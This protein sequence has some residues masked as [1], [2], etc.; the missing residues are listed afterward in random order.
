MPAS[1][2]H[3]LSVLLHQGSNW[4]NPDAYSSTVEVLLDSASLG[5][6][7]VSG[8][9]GLAYQDYPDWMMAAPAVGVFQ[10]N[11]SAGA[12]TV[13]LRQTGGN[14]CVE[15]AQDGRGIAL[16]YDE[17]RR[18]S[19]SVPNV[20][21]TSW[22]YDT[23]G[24]VMQEEKAISGAVTF[25]TAY[26]YDALDRVATMTYPGGEVVHHTYNAQPTTPPATC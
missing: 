20:D 12:H 26:T 11:A 14:A 15:I 5:T 9:L 3:T 24:R 19:T 23:R 25:V 16:D 2:A 6:V 22:S 18:R 4:S 8:G 17:G 21:I 7:Q 13:K 10:I 1:G